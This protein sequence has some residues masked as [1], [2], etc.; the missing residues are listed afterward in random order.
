MTAG[1]TY[2]R[3]AM[4]LHWLI[5]LMIIGVI[6]LGKM[7]TNPDIEFTLRFQLFQW[8]KT[9]G[10]MILLLSVLRLIW[11]LTHKYPSLPEAMKP[12]E[13]LGAKISHMGFYVLMIGMPL[14]GWAM[15]SSSPR[16]IPTKLF[17]KIP[18]PHIPGLS[19]LPKDEKET[20]TE[21]FTH[22]HLYAGYVLM[23]LIVLHVVAALKHHFVNKDN[24][25]SRM[26]PGLKQR[27]HL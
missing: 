21:V 2:N 1:V 22:L 9:L 15:V 17:G 16:N 24:I 19:N 13:V 4:S 23:A 18:W 14:V 6:V 11:R 3:V 7:M 5:A 12:W 8:H 10:I 27:P 26:L 25:L 20:V